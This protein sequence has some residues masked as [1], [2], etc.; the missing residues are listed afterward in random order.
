MVPHFFKGFVGVSVVTDGTVVRT[1][2]DEGVFFQALLFETLDDF[3]D[4]PV[5]L[6]DNVPTVTQPRFVA[7]AL[8]WNAW[9]MQIMGSEE[10]EER[11]VLVFQYLS[12]Q[13]HSTGKSICAIQ[14]HGAVAE[15]THS[16]DVYTDGYVSICT[17]AA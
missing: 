15:P 5:E 12:I 8:V 11:V 10:E 2:H 6:D 13:Y 3:S 17:G 16:V 14:F 1:K 9:N 7:K 4:A